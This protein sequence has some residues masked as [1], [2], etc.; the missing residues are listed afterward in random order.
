MTKE[1]RG[2]RFVRYAED[3]NVHVRSQKAGERVL[4]ALRKLYKRLHLKVN[5]AKSAVTS[6]FGR[7]LLGYCFW[8]GPGDEDKRAVADTAIDAFKR[9]IRLITRRSGGRSLPVVAMDLRPYLLGWKAYFHLAQTPRI[10][11]SL[12]EW[13]G[14]CLRAIQLK[15]WRRGTTAYRSLCSMGATR[16]L[17]A[18]VAS[19]ARRW[20]HNTSQGLHRVLP[21]AYF[22]RLGVPRLCCT[23]TS[24]TAR[25]GPACRVGWEGSVSA[26]DCPYPDST[27]SV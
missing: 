17:A 27:L 21:L 3:C 8:L 10:I 2:H 4:H 11:R 25:C 15:H 9:R 19:G 14:H 6:A 18:R 12:D 24:R 1:R 22:D 13:L 16:A 20:W 5:D 23:S 7:K 26:A